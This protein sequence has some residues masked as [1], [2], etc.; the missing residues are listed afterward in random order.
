MRIALTAVIVSIHFDLAFPMNKNSL[1]SV[2]L[3]H[4]SVKNLYF[5]SQGSPSYIVVKLVPTLGNVPGNCTLNSLVRYKSTVSSLLSPLAENLEYLQKTLTVSRGGRRRRFAGV[6]IGLAALGVA[7]AAQATAAVA[8]VEA[9][10]NAAQIQSL[11]EAIQNTNLAVNELKTA[12]GASATAIQAIQTQ[13][14]EVINPAINRL[15]CE[16]L[17]A[18]LASMLNLYLIHLT[19][20]FQNQLTNPALTPLSIQSLQSLLQGTSSVLT[21]ITSSSKLALND[22]L[23]TGLI[24]GQVVGL[25]MTSLQIVIAAYVPSVAKLSNAVVHNFIRITTSVNG[26]E[27]IIQSPTII[28]EQNEVMY[29]LKT[30]HCTESDLNIYCP[31][32]DA[33]LL[34]PGMTNCINGRLNDCTFSKVVGSFP[35]RFAAVEGAILANC[36]YLQCNCLTPPYIITPLNGEMISM[37]DL[38]KCQRL[39][40]GTIVF[41]INNPVNVTFNGNYRADVGQMIVTNPL[42]I[43]AELNQINT[44]LSNAQGFLSKSDAWLHVSQWVTNSGTI[45]IILIIGLI[46]GIVY[47]IIN[48]YVVVQIIKEI[49]RMRTSDRAHLLKGSISSIST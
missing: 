27:V 10:Q 6:A 32:V 5:Y 49:N 24:T 47:M 43:S 34:S 39:D 25:N 23:V 40:L 37:I 15:S 35:T 12:I 8:L 7:A 9:R 38:S 42:D 26:T 16:I 13:I 33:Q 20:V 11:S 17:D 4:K 14:N 30:G 19:T 31:Y 29:D 46:V 48:T 22:A 45:F 41:D 21:N 36:K 28:M 1:L 18:Q 3:V 2:G 44:S